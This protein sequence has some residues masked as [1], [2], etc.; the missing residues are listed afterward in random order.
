MKH[1]KI[2]LENCY[3][4]KKMQYQFDLTSGIDLPPEN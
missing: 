3:G 2:E 1:L 4:I